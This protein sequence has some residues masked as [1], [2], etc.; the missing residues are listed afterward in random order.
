MLQMLKQ[1]LYGIIIGIAL[2]GA[3]HMLIY[4]YN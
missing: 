3:I 4:I 1:F 2:M